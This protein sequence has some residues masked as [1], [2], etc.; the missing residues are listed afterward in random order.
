MKKPVKLFT[1]FLLSVFSTPVDK[2][3]QNKA[4]VFI[5]NPGS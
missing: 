5:Y 3:K 4:Y 1:L 2:P